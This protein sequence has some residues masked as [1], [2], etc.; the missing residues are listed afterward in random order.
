MVAEMVED[1]MQ[2]LPEVKS[3]RI[4]FSA[5][6]NGGFYVEGELHTETET[7]AMRE[8][9]KEALRP[10]LAEDPRTTLG[11]AQTG[12]IRLDLTTLKNTGSIKAPYSL[13]ADTGLVSVPIPKGGLSSF[14]AERDAT[15]QGVLAKRADPMGSGVSS[16]AFTKLPSDPRAENARLELHDPAKR[17]PEEPEEDPIPEFMQPIG[18]SKPP[19]RM[20]PKRMVNFQSNVQ[21]DEFTEHV[22]ETNPDRMRW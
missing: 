6:K 13:S 15:I 18:T 16:W 22:H 4:R 21:T 12:Q 14:R 10:V 17:E 19:V 20:K 8:R 2:G 7:D 1:A 9:L 11:P 5:G 3:T